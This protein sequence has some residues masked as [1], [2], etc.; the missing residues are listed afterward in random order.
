MTN[1]DAQKL[2]IAISSRALF[3]LDD[4]HHIFESEGLEAYSEYQIFKEE[5]VLSPGQAFQMVRKFLALNNHLNEPL[6]VEVILLSRNSAD[7]GLRIFNSIEHYGLNIT[8]AAFCGGEPPW[9]YI[10]AFGCQ[11]FLSAE[12]SD[13]RVALEHGVA[14]ATL[15]SQAA[16]ENEDDTLRLAFDGDAVR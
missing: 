12:G 14:A 2:V 10:D 13:V 15:V 11:L 3:D 4:A 8:R 5:E 16:S 9:R 6:G 7:T 1:V